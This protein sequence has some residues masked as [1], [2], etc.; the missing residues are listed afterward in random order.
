MFLVYHCFQ[1]DSFTL[2]EEAIESYFQLSKISCIQRLKW[3]NIDYNIFIVKRMQ[4][5]TFK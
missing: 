3:R 2:L 1:L 4:L 5:I